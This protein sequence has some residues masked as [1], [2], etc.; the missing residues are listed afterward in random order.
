MTSIS[1][2]KLNISIHLAREAQIALLIAEEV[3]KPNE[4]SD[5]A[6]V[7]SKEKALVLLERTNLNEHAIKLKD[8]API[9]FIRK[10][11]GSVGLYVDY[12][13][14]NNLI[15]KNQYLLP[16]ISESLDQLSQ[17]QQQT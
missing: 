15:I 7:F 13:G 16:L 6:D 14:L 1:F 2:S 3:K 12:W 17:A 11:D 4:Y 9:F 8:G 5:F 10:P